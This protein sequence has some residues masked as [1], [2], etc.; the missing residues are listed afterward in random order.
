MVG[1][2]L[3]TLSVFPNMEGVAEFYSHDALEMGYFMRGI[4]EHFGVEV[5]EIEGV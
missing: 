3:S 5:V 4:E 2:N 1:S